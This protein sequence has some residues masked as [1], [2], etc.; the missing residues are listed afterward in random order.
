MSPADR[1]M[2][3]DEAARHLGVSRAT[4]YAYVSRGLLQREALPGAGA[5]RSRY[6]ADAVLRLANQRRAARNPRQAAQATLDWG[7]PVLPS[8]LTLIESGRLH[9]R[10][11]DAEALAEQATLEDVAARL[12]QLDAAV[13]ARA[14]MAPA[15]LA[16]E[17]AAAL[18][19]PWR[20]VATPGPARCLATLQALRAG[21]ALAQASAPPAARAAWAGAAPLAAATPPEP[22][23][24]EA[25]ALLAT[26]RAA[27]TQQAVPARLRA[28]PLHRRLQAAWRLDAGQADLLRRALLLC[29]DH[30]LNAS[31]F[32]ARCVAATG[33]DLGAC[34]LAGLGALS[35]PRHGGVTTR[36]EARWPGWMAAAGDARRL[37]RLVATLAAPPEA[38]PGRGGAF[39]VG[40]GHPLY[41]QGDPRARHLL[42]RLPPDA[43]VARLLREVQAQTGWAPTIDFA[44]VALR[45]ALGLP[46]GAAFA[47]FAIGRTVGWIAHALEQRAQGS[48]IR[49][50]A[51]YVGEP[52]AGLAGPAA[53]APAGRVVRR[54]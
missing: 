40:F 31:S 52:P 41:P 19:A 5:R 20:R 22:L 38:G 37:R 44:L 39:T 43:R 7:L 48:L 16:A 46:E 49:P 29:A 2:S 25:L 21:Q 33:A 18:L 53:G 36:L 11:M 14:A 4:L 8:A 10:G 54:R 26:V 51:A 50:R 13:L 42:A 27:C 47:L 24:I 32:T 45:H 6:P 30:E 17:P 12:W 35:G 3:A 23:A 1:W 34:V 28:A 9:Y 15:V